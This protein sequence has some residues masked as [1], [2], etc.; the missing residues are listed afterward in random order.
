MY[1][2]AF[3]YAKSMTAAQV[4]YTYTTYG[5]FQISREAERA[6]Q[7]ASLQAGELVDITALDMNAYGTPSDTFPINDT[8][9]YGVL[10]ALLWKLTHTYSFVDVQVLQIVLYMLSFVLYYYCALWLFES[11]RCALMCTIAQLFFFPVI[12]MAV[13]PISDIWAYYGALMLLFLTCLTIKKP[14]AP[15]ESFIGGA[16]WIALCQ[17]IRPALFSAVLTMS[18]VLIVVTFLRHMSLKKTGVC[19]AILWSMN[20]LVFWMPFAAFNKHTYGRYIVG[21]FGQDLLEGL[22]EF[23][24]RWGYKLDD[25]WIADYIGTKYGVTYGTPEFDDAARKEFDSAYAQDPLFFYRSLVKRIPQLIL[26]A[27]T[28]IYRIDTPYSAY[29]SLSEKMRVTVTNKNLLFDF[30]A[31]HVYI[32][33]YLLLGYVGIVLLFFRKQYWVLLL[34][35]GGI[36]CGGLGKLP[37]HIEYRYVIPFYWV[38]SFFVGY[39]LQSIFQYLRNK[40]RR[41]VYEAV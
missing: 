32:R 10:L 23:S 7:D 13:Q 8:V 2:S 16:L 5:T 3:Y 24:N 20:L 36:L 14:D 11:S 33:L 35:L 6:H 38:F 25:Q 26:P 41:G 31:R 19:L 1:N 30:L 17:W 12:A 9:A 27:L 39:A 40:K 4:A 21:P 15:L 18:C 28:W 22:G 34:L 37:S 29:S